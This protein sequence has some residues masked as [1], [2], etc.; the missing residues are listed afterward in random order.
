MRD[1]KRN[2]NKANN[3]G[4]WIRSEKR[5]A[6]YAR[7]DHRCIYCGKEVH[8]GQDCTLD[9]LHP[10][11]LGGG[12]AARNLVTACKSCNSAKGSK[13]VRKFAA[14]LEAKG[15][16]TEEMIKRIRRTTRRSWK[17]YMK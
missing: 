12:N 5:A 1:R 8:K 7:D 13:T 17:K 11:E 10:Q 4:G 2:G 9:H 16:D 14:W 15:V 3:G 6:L